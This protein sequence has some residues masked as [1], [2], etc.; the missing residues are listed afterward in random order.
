MVWEREKKIAEDGGEIQVL[1]KDEDVEQI[2]E[3]EV[4]QVERVEKIVE[5]NLPCDP[6]QEITVE[7]NQFREEGSCRN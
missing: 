2:D 7:E 3:E 4:Q 6:E 1:E 5:V